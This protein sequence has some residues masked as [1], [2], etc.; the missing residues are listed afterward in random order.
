[1]G[2][3]AAGFRVAGCVE[4][5]DDS[6]RTLRYNRPRWKLAEPGDVFAHNPEE[7]LDAF[8]LDQGNVPLLVGGA[9]CQ[10]FSKSSYWLNGD[11]PRLNDPR[12]LTLQAYIGIVEAALP[13]VLLLENVKGLSYRG[14]DEG[15]TTKRCRRWNTTPD[16]C[17]KLSRY[18][19]LTSSA[20]VVIKRS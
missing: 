17:A 6:R 11:S 15:I 19:A 10:P 12:A 13:D 14:K 3:E 5:D 4:V 9:P 20:L 2:L 7:L 8:G 16:D 18:A 1:M